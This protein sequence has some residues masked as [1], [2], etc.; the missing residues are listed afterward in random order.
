MTIQSKRTGAKDIL[1]RPIYFGDTV[2][3]AVREADR[4]VLRKGTAAHFLKPENS[5]TI[6]TQA[7]NETPMIA[8]VEDPKRMV[9]ILVSIFDEEP[10]DGSV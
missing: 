7:R 3:Y 5:L 10:T 1:G 6:I 2:V 9:A 8:T 4:V